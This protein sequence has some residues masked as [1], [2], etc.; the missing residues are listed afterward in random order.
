MQIL[1]VTLILTVV[2]IESFLIGLCLAAWFR[3][4]GKLH[5]SPK[6]TE[7]DGLSEEQIEDL[8]KFLRKLRSDSDANTNEP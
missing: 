4:R 3:A 5:Y 2:A 6:W 1:I 8:K 7:L